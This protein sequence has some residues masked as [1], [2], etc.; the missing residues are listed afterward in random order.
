[1]EE[2]EQSEKRRQLHADQPVLEEAKVLRLDLQTAS[3]HLTSW[4]SGS[5]G[6]PELSPWAQYQQC[7]SYNRDKSLWLS[8][9]KVDL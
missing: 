1:M 2:V 7:S 8:T 9:Q 3:E 4:E 6:D 5:Q